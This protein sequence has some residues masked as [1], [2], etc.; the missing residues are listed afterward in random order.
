MPARPR[1]AVDL[2]AAL[3]SPTGIGVHTRELLAG[4]AARGAF[5][6]VAM[7]H[8]PPADGAW[9]RE[10]GIAVESQ[11]APNGV[12]W[13]QLRL[14]R[15]LG[16]GDLDLFWSPLQTLPLLG[17]LPSVVTVHDLT[18]LILPETHRWKVRLSQV[19]LLGRSLQRAARIVAVSEHTA[20]DV[21]RHFPETAP[22]LRVVPCGVGD[23]FVPGRAE[24][25]AATRA[26][27]GAPQG[28]LLYAGTLEP[29][30]NL[31]LLLDAWEGM[32]A[33]DGE[34]PPLVI[35]GGYGWRSRALMA[36][37]E[38]LREAGV[39]VLGRVAQERLV[40]LL[41]AARCFVFPSLYE[42][43]GLPPMEALACGVPVVATRAGSLPEVLGDA[44]L[45][46]DPH[47]PV[48]LAHAIR[49]VLGERELA[50]DLAARGPRRAARYTWAASAEALE[51]VLLEALASAGANG[52]GGR[53]PPAWR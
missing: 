9:L 48:E 20:A 10:L 18:P 15:R 6:L 13:Q 41:Q 8:R 52:A 32:L 2:R 34:A 47:D 36:R 26:G 24:A 39:R 3:D 16:R 50:A 51:G 31:P 25:I 49:R 30:K 53:R 1:L 40:A 46:V 44:A 7:A 23:E 21:R 38:G 12:W 14:P 43:F 33:E 5:E 27:L 29:R 11:A 28:Y 35:A 22:R 42:G 45:L 19:P 17:E 37:L 4:L